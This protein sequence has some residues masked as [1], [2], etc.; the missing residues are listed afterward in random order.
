MRYALIIAGGAGTR[1]W[2][3]STHDLPKQLIPFID[4]RSLLQLAVDRLQGLIPAERIYICAGQAHR[5]AMLEAIDGL[6]A[7]RFIGEP[8][9]RDTLNAVGLGTGVIYRQDPEASVAVFTA[10]HLIEPTDQF[11]HM[12]EAGY[13]LA[14]AQPDRLVTFGVEPTYAATGYG[15]LQLG[16]AIAD[17]HASQVDRFKEKP[18]Q[19]TA[20]QYLDAGP[21]QYLW[22][23][24]MFVFQARTMMQR[25]ERFTPENHQGLQQAIEA[26]ATGDDAALAQVYPQLPKISIDYAVMEPAADD[27]QTQ[28]VALPLAVRWLDVGS[29]PAFGQTREKDDAGNAVGDCQHVGVDTRDS[30][31]VADDDQHVIGTIGLEQMIIVRTR[32]AT[33]VCRADRAQDIKKLREQVAA[34]VGEGYV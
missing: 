25:I 1:L 34:Q 11:Q 18:D 31:I 12:V 2:P 33:L 30:I 14:K 23:S 8:T 3:M 24:G 7:D 26:W 17:S 6:T 32:Q 22:N 29:W 4:G 9:G 13:D 27:A 10:D 28:V 19:A 5:Q 21:S 16:S 15:Y 20:R